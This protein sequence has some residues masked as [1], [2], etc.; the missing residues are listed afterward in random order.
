MIAA[1]IRAGSRQVPEWAEPAWHLFIVR[2]PERDQLQ[3]RLAEAGVGTLIHY[4]VPPRRQQAY[5][6][7]GF[8]EGAF[9]IA[10]RMAAEVLSLPMGPQLD[11]DEAET[12]VAAVTEACRAL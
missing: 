2:H 3:Q 11:S 7:I 8:Q 12:V 9:L 4:P 5:A 6:G 1:S 10:S